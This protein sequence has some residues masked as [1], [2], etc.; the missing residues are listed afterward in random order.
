MTEY[1]FTSQFEIEWFLNRAD[2][3]LSVSLI[4]E[5]DKINSLQIDSQDDFDL[6]EG[7]CKNKN[8]TPVTVEYKQMEIKNDSRKSG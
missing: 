4:D 3:I 1:L 2:Q 8:I 7:Y 5:N 6:I